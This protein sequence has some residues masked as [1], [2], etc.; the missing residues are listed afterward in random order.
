MNSIIILRELSKKVA[1]ASDSER[2]VCAADPCSKCECRWLTG[3]AGITASY[4]MNCSLLGL[5]A[6]GELCC[7]G[8]TWVN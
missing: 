6:F 7:F 2:I 1:S 4:V 5:S 8:E 3:M